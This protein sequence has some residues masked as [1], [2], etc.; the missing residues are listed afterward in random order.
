MQATLSRAQIKL[1]P[2]RRYLADAI[3]GF[4]FYMENVKHLSPHTVFHYG[5]DLSLFMRYLS[6]LKGVP[7]LELAL[8]EVVPA[9][10]DGFL[11]FLTAERGNSQRS[12]KRRL[13]ALRT[14]FAYIWDEYTEEEGGSINPAM[15]VPVPRIREAPPKAL[16]EG[17]TLSLL[18]AARAHAPYPARDYCLLQVFLS[19]GARLAEVLELSLDDCDIKE[20]YICLGRGTKRERLLPLDT[21]AIHALIAYLATRPPVATDRVFV[22]RYGRPITKGA[23]YHLMGRCLS[24]ADLSDKGI[25]IHTL[26]HTC[27]ARMAREGFSPQALQGLAGLSRLQTPRIYVKMA[28]EWM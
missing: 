22:N 27:F 11:H 12:A 6:Q 4:L 13:A 14:F 25:T 28:T 16:T 1:S 17:E 5:H 21:E 19:C 24:A 23:I 26:R 20:G 9:H 15:L 7:L 18:R 10:I 2:K 3:D 8:P